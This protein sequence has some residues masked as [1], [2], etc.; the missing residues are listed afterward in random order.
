[1]TDSSPTL[2]AGSDSSS[3]S[4]NRW[5]F[6][7]TPWSHVRAADGQDEHVRRHALELLCTAYWPPLYAFVHRKV[8]DLHLAQ[9]LTQSFFERMLTGRFLKMAD[10]ARGRFR[11]FLIRAF[12]WHLANEFREERAAK[13]GGNIQVIELD[14]SAHSPHMV[15]ET[16]STA[17]EQFEREWGLRLLSLTMQRLQAEQADP[18]KLSQFETLKSFLAG[19]RPTGGYADACQT[20]G[21]SEPAARM[22]VSRLR[23]RFRELIRDEI[24]KTV[25]SSQDIDDEIQH[26]FRV[27]S[28]R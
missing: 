19:D 27:L 14:F 2:N 13:R 16:S 17:E 6:S 25:A 28:S 23:S 20:L 12:E 22:A 11:T 15:D 1:M 26:L 21:L 5:R 18:L 24:Q 9:D 3:S 10:P 7:S 8:K 4:T